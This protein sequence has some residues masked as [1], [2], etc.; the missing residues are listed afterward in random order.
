MSKC[1]RRGKRDGDGR[2][3]DGRWTVGDGRKFRR[4]EGV[5]EGDFFKRQER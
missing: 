3:E 4:K 2:R 1:R 5:R